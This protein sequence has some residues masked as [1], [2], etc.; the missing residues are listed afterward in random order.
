MDEQRAQVW[1]VRI[2]VWIAVVAVLAFGSPAGAQQDPPGDESDPWA[3]LRL[4]AGTWE[5]AIDGK[6]GKGK[7]L[8][9]Y[10]FIVGGKYLMSRHSS[11]RMPQEKS[12]GGDQHENLGVFSFDRERKT[13]VYRQFMIEDVVVRYTCDAM[14]NKLVCTSEAVESGPGMRARLTLEISN[15][16]R[17]VEAYEIGWPG[18][19]LELYFTNTWT[20]T[21]TVSE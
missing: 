16:Y 15:R 17:F 5:G 20:R 3:Q 6:L 14:A 1:P 18:K 4:L 13:L 19:E 8:R 7:G 12:P 9:R 21:P 11:V 10:E 2:G